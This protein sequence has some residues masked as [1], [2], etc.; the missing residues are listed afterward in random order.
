VNTGEDG[1]GFFVALLLKSATSAP[2]G[3]NDPGTA[4]P[5]AKDVFHTVFPQMA[6]TRPESLKHGFFMRPWEKESRFVGE[7]HRH[8]KAGRKGHEGAQAEYLPLSVLDT[9]YIDPGLL[10]TGDIAVFNGTAHFLPAAHRDLIPEKTAWKGFVLGKTGKQGDLR[11]SPH[12]RGLMPT[13]RSAGDKGLALIN[14]EDIAPLLSLLQGQ[15]LPLDAEPGEAGLY[16]RG[17]PL[18]RLALKG[19]RAML[20]PL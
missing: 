19:R 4:R 20:P 7:R 13:A 10:P 12:L 8:G 6:D 18:C 9:G 2:A 11:L 14:L 17:L 1:Q 16:Y 5:P 3:M 15:G